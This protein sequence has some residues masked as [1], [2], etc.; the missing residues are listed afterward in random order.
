MNPQNVGSQ[1]RCCAE[2]Y[3]RRVRSLIWPTRSRPWHTNRR[4]VAYMVARLVRLCCS[5]LQKGQLI[6]MKSLCLTC[7]S[8]H[9]H[10]SQKG[11][12][13]RLHRKHY[14]SSATVALAVGAPAPAPAFT[15]AGVPSAPDETDSDRPRCTAWAS[16]LRLMRCFWSDGNR[17]NAGH[18]PGRCH[19]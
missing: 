3:L 12:G 19:I 13:Y 10:L 14:S 1:T 8:S 5:F 15:V 7:G 6:Q 9:R 2:I 16:L 11:W 4:R 18:L 17:G